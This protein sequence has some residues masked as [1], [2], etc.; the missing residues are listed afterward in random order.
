M[1]LSLFSTV[2]SNTEIL[3]LIYVINGSRIWQKFPRNLQS[4]LEVAEFKI[5]FITNFGSS[6]DSVEVN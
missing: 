2:K 5:L 3:G 6:A 4:G 1:M